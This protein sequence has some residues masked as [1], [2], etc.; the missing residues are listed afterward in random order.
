M[1]RLRSHS[2]STDVLQG[3]FFGLLFFSETVFG[4]DHPVRKPLKKAASCG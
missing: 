3:F 4:G 1:F 2:L